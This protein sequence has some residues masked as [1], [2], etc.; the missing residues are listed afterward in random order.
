MANLGR[1]L[2]EWRERKLLTQEQLAERSG[3]SV[4]T[5]RRYERG[6]S[7]QTT[8][9]RMLADA[10]GLS[11]AER[12]VLVAAIREPSTV[13]EVETDAPGSPG[14]LRQLPG[15]PPLFTGRVPEL[16]ELDRISD[17]DRLVIATISG[18][19]GVG[20]TALA[21]RAAHA[22]ASRYPDE[23]IYLDLHGYAQGGRPVDPAEALDRVL[24]SLGVPAE[25][26]PPGL[27]DRAALYRSR[28]A[29]H[30]ALILLDNAASEEQ[31][32][33]LLPGTPGSLVLV[34]SRH[35]LPGLDHSHAVSLG[36]LPVSDAVAL[37]TLAAGER[38][39][40]GESTDVTTTVDLCGRLPLAVHV[41]AARLR[42]HPS[43]TLAHLVDRLQ[44]RRRLLSELE[45]GERSV[46][47]ALD[48]SYQQ[49]SVELR[50]AYR[51]F[52]LH[53]GAELTVDAAAALL[54]TTE[55]RAERLIDRLLDGH[56]VLEPVPGRFRFHDLVRAHSVA[57]ADA[58][59]GD[60]DE[61][62][63]LTRLFDHYRHAAAV[64]MDVA[65]PYERD[66]RP[67]IPTSGTPAP[68]LDGPAGA[69]AWLDTE[70]PTLL[71]VARH[72]ADHGWPDH[73]V[74]LSGTLHRHLRG[75][76]HYA[77]AETLHHMA[78]TV[79]R[80]TGNGLAEATALVSLG[81]THRQQGRIAQATD[82]YERA[83]AI[84]VASGDRT[85]EMW[86]LTALGHAQ[87]LQGRYA[88]AAEHFTRA[89]QI[90]RDIGNRGAELDAVG[91]L[92]W[93]R[94]QQ[95]HV[96]EAIEAFTQARQ[97]A[98]ETA[99]RSGELDALTGLGWLHRQ[100]GHNE[101]AATHF[102]QAL[103][104][105]RAIGNRQGELNALNGLASTYRLEGRHQEAMTTF[106]H[107]LELS[108]AIGNRNL[109]FE[110]LQGLGRLHFAA[111]RHDRALTCHGEALDLAT[112]LRQ[113]ADQA[114]AHDGIAHA[115]QALGQDEDARRHW[116]LALETL[117]A[118][119]AEHTE[120][121]EVTTAGLRALLA[122]APE[123]AG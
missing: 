32:T 19:A 26:I 31:V 89:G 1:L 30:R 81:N 5:V 16:A 65:Y 60:T 117:A 59:E 53:P 83:L 122:R 14:R 51:V 43:W 95:G 79:A 10:L 20:K 77:L 118:I 35:Q 57:R 41:A 123:R 121:G 48:L 6:G 78:L 46:T 106:E 54:G 24:R 7:P 38:R 80:A 112:A 71:A 114:N 22:V 8:S 98:R 12:A 34:T 82:H 110:A 100:Q 28:L 17:P 3:V 18:M 104:I 97:L 29:D 84:A 23:Q 105:S 61:R 45:A 111:G 15:P 74:H 99:N 21:V 37:F 47:A 40:R 62:A 102:E 93:L 49:L 9:I 101:P 87:R 103:H 94:R 2:R 52:G 33:P 72:A 107:T 44:V 36:L 64:A 55:Q 76:A 73:T 108:R 27:D 88:D 75:R 67:R 63:A 109:Q 25:R 11:P 85:A 69:M 115:H 56:L 4:R 86:T 50:R 39:V 66:R 70:L 91:G 92:G 68:A 113:P 42:S 13:D 96:T 119:G 120:D 116:E 90:A 58:D